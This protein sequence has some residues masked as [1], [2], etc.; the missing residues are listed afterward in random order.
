MRPAAAH[1][2]L[3]LT[4]LPVSA[5]ALDIATLWDFARP[6]VSEQRFRDALA[7]A[8]GDTALILHTQIARTHGLRRDFDTARQVLQAVEPQVASAGAEA[9]V[10]YHLELGRTLA[11]AAHPVEALTPDAKA[12]ARQAYTRA[13]ERARAARLDGLAIDAI[14]MMA[15]VDTS[16]ADQLAWGEAALAVVVS[17]TQPEAMRWEASVR[18]N[19]GHA[20]NE[21]GRHAEALDQFRQALAIRERGTN[22]Q[23]THV[24]R[25]MVAR[26]LRSLARHDEALAMQ[27]ALER[28][29]DGAGRPDPYVFEELEALYRAQGDA[30]RARHYAARRATTPR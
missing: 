2:A 29:A 7:T 30:E 25:W 15:F 11:S 1:L 8:T 4:L 9:Q 13:L 5:M 23:A 14:H 20:L 3:G 6:D 24:A 26:T 19:I 28:E 21:L 27:L 18:H 16:P 17:S 10:R 22:A 12:R